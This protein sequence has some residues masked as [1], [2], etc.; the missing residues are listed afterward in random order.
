[1]FDATWR[2]FGTVSAHHGALVVRRDDDGP[3]ALL[4]AREA[5][6]AGVGLQAGD[7]IEFSIAPGGAAADMCLATYSGDRHRAARVLPAHG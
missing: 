3:D 7:R 1:M 6:K 2:Y 4:S 5:A